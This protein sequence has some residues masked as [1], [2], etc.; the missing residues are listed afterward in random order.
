[1]R[2]V[3]VLAR[4]FRKA[5]TS[6]NVGSADSGGACPAVVL[7]T[8]TGVVYLVIASLV[9]AFE[10]IGS[11]VAIMISAGMLPNGLA[12]LMLCMMP[13]CKLGR[14]AVKITCSSNGVT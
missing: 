7:V 3:T 9:M 4:A 6:L 2:A 8:T 13:R 11:F 5:T 14:Y 1:M 10:I 12:E